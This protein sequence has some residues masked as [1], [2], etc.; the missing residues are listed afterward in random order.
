MHGGN[1]KGAPEGN[2]HAL[3]HGEHE[4]IYLSALSDDER[5]I[6]EKVDI[7]KR[8]NLEEQLR[9]SSVR[10]YRMLKRMDGKKDTEKQ[11][12]E[13]AITRV[14]ARHIQ[15]LDQVHKMDAD[16][17]GDDGADVSSFVNVLAEAASKLTWPQKEKDAGQ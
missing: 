9:L 5:V 11:Y 1:N 3:K 12:I 17:P 4:S 7:D 16:E 10:I 2:K 14:V 13:D 6:F 8:R 15:M